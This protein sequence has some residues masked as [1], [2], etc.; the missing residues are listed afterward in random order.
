[1]NVLTSGRLGKEFCNSFMKN[2][3]GITVKYVENIE[4]VDIDWA[5]C[6]AS[7]AP[8]E[9]INLNNIKWIHSFGAGVESFLNRLDLNNNVILS[10]TVGDLGFKMGEFCLC[11]LLNYSQNFYT[12]RDNQIKKKWIQIFPKSIK[13]KTALIL[14]T[15]QMAQGISSVLKS[16]GVNTVGVNRS[17]VNHKAFNQCL[18]FD[19]IHSISR[20]VDFVINTLPFTNDT[21]NLLSKS[22][23]SVFTE[24]LFINVGR[25]KTVNTTE[26]K[27]ALKN[28]NCSYAVLD[29]F[30]QEPLS[31]DSDLWS[32]SKIFITPHQSAITDIN[33]IIM[34]FNSVYKSI[35]GNRNNELLVNINKG[36]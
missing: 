31:K 1:M 3:F 26:L 12:I 28:G 11:H 15:G 5:D 22:F 9:D 27:L 36:Y 30:E 34:S 33:D 2:S 21:E 29:V 24:V 7:F 14:G 8:N 17:G 4:Q 10:R 18:N 20:S 32:N 13:N 19:D 25:G 6:L 35:K 23:F 16:A